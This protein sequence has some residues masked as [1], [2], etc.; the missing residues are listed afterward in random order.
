M[1]KVDHGGKTSSVAL[2]VRSP[3][4][5]A[6][7]IG[8]AL[9]LALPPLPTALIVVG[10]GF[11]V[12]LALNNPVFGLY[13]MV[14]SVP[15][16]QVVVLPNGTS[17]TQAATMLAVIAWALRR[18]AYPR[19]SFRSGPL[20]PLWLA[21]LGAMLLSA[22]L[23]P[24]SPSIALREISRWLVMVVAWLVGVNTVRT[25]AE[26]AGLVACLLLAPTAESLIGVV[27]FLTGNG[28]P[29]FQIAGS[30]HF[31]RAY[32]TIGTP[33]AFA[34]YLNMAWPL[35]VALACAAT[36]HWLRHDRRAWPGALGLWLV[37]GVLL[38]GVGA[39]FSLGGWLGAAAGAVALILALGRVGQIVAALAVGGGAAVFA[40]GG[41]GLLPASVAARLS[42]LNGLTLFDPATVQVTPENF[43]VVERM[44]QMWAGWQMFLRYPLTGVGPG[45]YTTAYQDVASAPWYASR[46]HAHNYYIH[47]M[48]ENGIIGLLAFLAVLVGTV[49]LGIV[50]ARRAPTPWWRAVAIGCCGIIISVA[51]HDLFENLHALNFGIQTAGVLVVLSV[52]ANRGTSPSTS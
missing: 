18:C 29:S 35:A 19:E 41:S 43:A 12:L 17:F 26:L 16:Q 49:L 30:S 20:L 8:L 2:P 7:L 48:A 34:G 38:L 13:W 23:T 42:R 33:N 11:A 5:W 45:N 21:L 4:F 51:G 46:G 27:Q 28:P 44:A 10:S 40:G 1:K 52:L 25:R 50:A 22:S 32:G 24:Y 47:F 6:G 3:W 37:A 31:V 39:S 15:I 36:W 14:L 9:A